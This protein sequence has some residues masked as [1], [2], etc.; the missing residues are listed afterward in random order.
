MRPTGQAE[1]VLSE[2]QFDTNHYSRFQKNHFK[3]LGT[4]KSANGENIYSI[5]HCRSYVKRLE[6][7]NPYVL[8]ARVV[9]MCFPSGEQGSGFC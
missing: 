5:I 1:A 3:S 8:Q 4:A 7:S 6:L 9:P 2:E